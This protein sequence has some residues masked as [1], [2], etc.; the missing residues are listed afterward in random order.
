MD[1]GLQLW[2][3]SMIFFILGEMLH[4]MQTIKVDLSGTRRHIVSI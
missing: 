4:G 1:K 2:I 3:I